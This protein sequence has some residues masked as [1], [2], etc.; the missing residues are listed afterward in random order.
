MNEDPLPQEFFFFNFQEPQPIS[1]D[2]VLEAAGYVSEKHAN[3]YGWAPAFDRSVSRL[4]IR[5][6]PTLLQRHKSE[7]TE[8]ETH[9]E[10]R[11]AEFEPERETPTPV[12]RSNLHGECDG[13]C[14][15]SKTW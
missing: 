7:Q 6:Y 5:T 4:P 9:G 8:S 13:N 3:V 1:E 12:E 14:L 11:Q 10:Q 2:P 15:S